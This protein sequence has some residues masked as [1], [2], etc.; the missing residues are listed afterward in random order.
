[1]IKTGFNRI[2]HIAI[3]T[4]IVAFTLISSVAQSQTEYGDF[5]YEKKF[6]K[7]R[8]VIPYPPLR[9]ADVMLMWRIHRIID[10]REK[11]N[12]IM[13]WPRSPFYRIIYESVT[14]GYGSAPL[15]A[16]KNDSLIA[17]YTAEEILKLGGEEE[18]I[19]YY[20]DPENYP[21]Y[22]IDSVVINP[23]RPE[24]IVKYKIMEDYIFDKQRSLFFWRIIAIAPMFQPKAGGIQLAEQE[25]FWVKWEDFKP[26]LLNQEIFN[27]HNDAMR[28]NYLDWFEHRMFTSYI[29]KQSNAFDNAITDFAEFKSD[30]F[31]AILESEKIKENLFFFEHDLWEW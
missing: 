13:K 21:D 22:Y 6:I 4:L 23:F 31:A 28:M 5:T 1:M 11:M 9:E 29:T 7:E 30:P 10:S 8:A 14:Q 20:P 17:F 15:T 24:K 2:N 27:R 25:M 18:A 12:V 16:Y 3:A 19:Q 26:I